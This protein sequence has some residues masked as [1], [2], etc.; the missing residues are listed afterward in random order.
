[1]QEST[2]QKHLENL[3]EHHQLQLREVMKTWKVKIILKNIKTSTDTIK[4]IDKKINN[5][6]ISLDDISL[7]LAIIKGKYKKKSSTYFIQWY[8]KV[9]CQ[10]KC[11]NNQNQILSCRIKF[12]KLQATINNLEFNKKEFLE[13]INNQTTIC[14]LSKK[15]KSKFVSWQ[16]HKNNISV[17]HTPSSQ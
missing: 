11:Y 1:L 3:V 15:E 4:S 6:Q 5:K 12:Q 14:E 8:Q 7:V 2:I 9:N 17:L 13:L 16:E 10:R